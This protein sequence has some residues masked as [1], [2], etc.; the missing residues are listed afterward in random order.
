MPQSLS[1]SLSGIERSALGSIARTGWQFVSDT[2][3]RRVCEM[4]RMMLL[5]V[6]SDND[7]INK[8]F[9]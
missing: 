2:R 1:L 4:S 6:V 3:V 5:L 8:L 7:A 9:K